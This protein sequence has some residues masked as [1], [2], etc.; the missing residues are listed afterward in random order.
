MATYGFS[1]GDA[2]RIG[3]VVRS[4]EKHPHTIRLQSPVA[5]G[6][7]PGVRLLIAKLEGASGWAKQ[8][9]AVVTIY[10]GDPVASAVTVVARNQFVTFASGTACTQQWV[11]LGHN[12]WGWQAVSRERACDGTCSMDWAGVDFS[13]IPGFEATKVQLLGHSSSGP[14][15]QW[16]SVTNVD[17]VTHVTLT[18]AA[19]EFQRLSVG[20]VATQTAST[21]ALS[22]T[23][24]AT[25]S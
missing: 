19:V 22:I 10:N 23:T 1:D 4:T 8:T 14:C 9:T 6:A 15:M 25:A 21:I 12:G 5:E 11:A 18:T 13:V 2:K 3:R 16:Y 20:V 24:C 17:V 7:A